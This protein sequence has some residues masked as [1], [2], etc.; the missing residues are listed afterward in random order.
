[1]SCASC[2]VRHAMHLASGRD[3]QEN[4]H[5]RKYNLFWARK[6]LEIFKY[7]GH[8]SGTEYA[9]NSLYILNIF[10][11]R[12]SVELFKYSWDFPPIF[13]I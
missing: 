9:G 7:L 11:F 4:K 5:P 13:C 10:H 12:I 6:V 2:H 1:M 3:T 8:F